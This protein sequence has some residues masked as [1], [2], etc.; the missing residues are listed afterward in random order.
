MTHFPLHPETPEEGRTLEELFAGRGVN[1]AA[2]NRR[3]KGLMDSEELPYGERTMTFNSRLAQEIAK[4]AESQPE[5][6][7]IHDALFRAYFVEGKN[8]GQAE[9]LIEVAEK[10]GLNSTEAR[11]VLETRQ[12]KDAVDADW[13]RSWEL[14]VTGVP[15]Y[16]IGG[17]KLVG[18]QPY[19]ELERFFL[20]ARQRAG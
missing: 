4:W 12:F 9:I 19:E 10:N 20:A 13:R 5:G 11:R 1:V 14:G 7:R 6:D 8:I 18:A 2:M 3:M 15:T 16:V 17:L